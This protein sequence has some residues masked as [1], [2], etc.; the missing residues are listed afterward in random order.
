MK[1]DEGP[2]YIHI[3]HVSYTTRE[4]RLLLAGVALFVIGFWGAI[5]LCF[6]GQ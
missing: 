4:R 1:R 6:W 3:K 2:I 5:A